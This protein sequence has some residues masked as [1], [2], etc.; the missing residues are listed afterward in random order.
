M[1]PCTGL[2]FIMAFAACLVLSSCA[3]EPVHRPFTVLADL[4]ISF[5]DAAWD[6]KTIPDGQQC[7]AFGGHGST[8]GLLIDNLPPKANALI[9]AFS[10]ISHISLDGGGMGRIGYRFKQGTTTLTLPPVPG[11]I[12][13]LPPPFFVITAHQQ[14]FQYK[15]GAYLPPCSGGTGDNYYLLV[16]AIWLP[17]SADM[18]PEVLGRGKIAL[19]RY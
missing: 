10:N 13:D 2:A 3:G 9:L 1:K 6:G 18:Q 16:K 11:N 15:P 4:K 14:P 5:T 7:E 12:F 17:D 19:G 8:P